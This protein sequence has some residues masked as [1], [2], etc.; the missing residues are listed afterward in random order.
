VI[1][2]V[3]EPVIDNAVVFNVG[4]PS[5]NTQESQLYRAV[6]EQ[7]AP[8]VDPTGSTPTGYLSMLGFVRAV[9]AGGLTGDVT[10]DAV[11]AAVKAARDVPRPIGDSGTFSCDRSAIPTTLVKATICSSELLYTT[12]S[13]G[14]PGRY[15]KIDIAPVFR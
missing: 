11:H 12:Y 9:N 13:G 4:D 15:G 10:P 2:A 14:L 5:G 1:E 8:D 3:G 6:M 7:Y